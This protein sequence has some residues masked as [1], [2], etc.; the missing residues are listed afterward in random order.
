MRKFTALFSARVAW[1]VVVNVGGVVAADA[2]AFGWRSHIR[3]VRDVADDADV[4]LGAG[5]DEGP[6]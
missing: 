1:V 3:Q 5:E 6:G 4:V 2:A